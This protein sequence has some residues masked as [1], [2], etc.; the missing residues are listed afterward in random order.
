M[1]GEAVAPAPVLLQHVLRGIQFGA[2]EIAGYK[3]KA[4]S[5]AREVEAMLEARGRKADGGNFT[6]LRALAAGEAEPLQAR[7]EPCS[8]IRRNPGKLPDPQPVGH[9]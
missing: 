8:C 6:G 5:I 4:C 3:G 2:L 9:R 7:F 1:R